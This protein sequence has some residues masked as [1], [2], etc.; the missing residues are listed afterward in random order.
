ML[1]G[2]NS[3]NNQ[4][5]FFLL[6]LPLFFFSRF[7]VNVNSTMFMT[8]EECHT[9]AVAS[10]LL[11]HGIEFPLYQ[12]TPEYYENS[13]LVSSFLATI[14]VYLLGLNPLSVKLVPFF[15]AYGCLVLGCLILLR[16]GFRN[17]IWFYVVCFLFGPKPFHL[18]TLDGVGN[19]ILGAFMGLT[20]L[21]LFCGYY[22]GGKRIHFFLW[23]FFMGLGTFFHMSTVLFSILSVAVWVFY[24]P[25]SGGTV[26]RPAPAPADLETGL[27]FFLAGLV[28][29]GFFLAK[30]G[31]QSVLFLLKNTLSQQPE[32]FG[33]V[34]FIRAVWN[35]TLYQV[36]GRIW[37]LLM[38]PALAAAAFA[39]LL[40]RKERRPGGESRFI[41][42]I[43]VAVL[44]PVWGAV[45]IYGGVDTPRYY[46]Y[47]Y[48]VQFMLGG[49][50]LSVFLDPLL[51]R[52]GRAA[53]VLRLVLAAA[54][55]CL[56]MVQGFNVSY[57]DFRREYITKKERAVCYWR[58]GRAFSNYTGEEL[59]EKEYAAEMI[60]KC[61][62]FDKEEKRN[63]CYWGWGYMG[64]SG[65]RLTADVAAVLGPERSA[66][67]AKGIGAGDTGD[68]RGRCFSVRVSERFAG[69]C[70]S[71]CL[72][73][74]L[75]H[76]IGGGLTLPCGP[77]ERI[78]GGYYGEA[79]KKARG[80]TPEGE[81]EKCR[82]MKSDICGV[83]AGYCAA[84]EGREQLC[85][86]ETPAPE[87]TDVCGDVYMKLRRSARN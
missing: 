29:F 57:E 27:L 34:P 8:N 11:G 69:D 28:P 55:S 54:F 58:F 9:G 51:A 74:R 81:I 22:L 78:F 6:L 66:A 76:G 84:V 70:I 13:I 37:M 56:L 82:R 47:L 41:L 20:I 52:G 38:F 53:G 39:M 87:F 83:M 1:S 40:S 35:A 36:D 12:Y 42:F 49:A 86:L 14:P 62:R 46:T 15:F 31:G 80:G 44:V 85:G 2:R 68:C 67:L 21:Y 79:M 60:V 25:E 50:V 43:L 3:F 16:G 17:G 64:T 72:E 61:G 5:L 73:S 18:E 65:L 32:Q 59:E 23:M 75:V 7:L 24:R 77:E 4:V 10:E 48:P 63:E 33:V 19:H 30:T 45:I 26:R 71:G